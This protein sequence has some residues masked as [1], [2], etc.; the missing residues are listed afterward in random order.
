MAELAPPRALDFH[1]AIFCALPIEHDAAGALFDQLYETEKLLYEASSGDSNAYTTGRIGNHNVV[2]VQMPGIG[3]TQAATAASNAR[4]TFENLKLALV[5][6]VCGGAP[7]ADD[8]TDIFLG[9]IIVSGRIVQFDFARQYPNKSLMKTHLEGN[10]ALPSS[11]ISSFLAKASGH[12]VC[13]KITEKMLKHSEDILQKLAFQKFR[14]PGE[15]HDKLYLSD[16][17]HKHQKMGVC[18]ICDACHSYEDEVC[19]IALKESCL[20]LGCEDQY[21]EIRSQSSRSRKPVIHFG[22]IASSDMVI[23]SGQRRDELVHQTKVIGFEMEGAGTSQSL[24]TIVVKAVCG[25]S[26]N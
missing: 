6:G 15:H 13:P 4:A 22:S 5:V 10:L 16:Y 11:E 12:L 21:L 26:L 18:T 2:L 24:P 17:R 25:K 19:G 1:I 20:K 23:K 7:K 3:K 14:Y 8:E 9:D